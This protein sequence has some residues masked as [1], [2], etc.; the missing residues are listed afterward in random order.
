MKMVLALRHRRLP[1]SLHCETP[2]PHVD[3]SAGEVRLLRETV[4]WQPN[5][6]PRRAGV[7]AFGISGT[8][9]HTII[10]EAPG[11]PA[12]PNES[13]EPAE[14][15]EP[16]GP[17]RPAVLTGGSRA[18]LVSGRTPDGLRAQAARLAEFVSARADQDPDDITD[19]TDV[20]WSLA[21]SRSSFEHRAVVLG[22]D[23]ETLTSGLAALAAGGSAPTVVSGAVPAGRPKVGLLFAGQ[24]AQRAGM[25]RE[26]YAA[27]PAFAA[28]FDQACALLEAELELPIREVVLGDE[29]DERADQTVYAQTG[30]F[31]V[32]VGLVALLAEA[33]IVPDAVA[34]HSV[35]EIAAAHA[36]GVLTLADASRLVA[37]RARLMQDLPAGGAMAAVEAGEA[38][39][40]E[41]LDGLPGVEI[42]AVNGPSA[43]VIS[44]DS[45]AVGQVLETWRER[46]RRV[47]RLRVSHAFHSARM[48]PVLDE[49][50][51]VATGLEHRTPT[52]TWAGAC[53]GTI[54]TAPEPGY[55]PAQAR[56]AV[57]F[58]D[59]VAALAGQGVSVF[60]EIGP[61]ATLSA[62]G[63]AALPA[64][65]A[66]RAETEAAGAAEPVFI[67]LLR[68][69]TSAADAVLTA[70]ARAHV[71]GI[72]VDWTRVLPAGTRV[73]LPTYAFRRQ[74]FW[75]LGP[76]KLRIGPVTGD[77]HA[78]GA[79]EARFWAAVESGDRPALSEALAV[80]DRRLD[81]LLPV[82]AA[83][84]RRERDRSA[85]D[86]WR[87]RISWAPVAD[88]E[89]VTLSGTWLVVT[90]TADAEPAGRCVQALTGHGA[91]AVVV[92]IS[93]ET[94]REALAA[95]LGRAG[96][97][98]ASG[99]VS[100]LALDETP[101]PDRPAVTGGL[102]AT[103]SLIQALGD[104][105]AQ[106]PLWVLTSGAVATDP[107]E[108][109]ARPLQAQVWGLG[110]VAGLEHPER[111]GGLIDLPA[112]LDD[113][114]AGR[115][116][117]V[118]AGNGE[119][120]V[121]IRSAGIRA[122]RLVRAPGPSGT[123]PGDRAARP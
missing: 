65:E 6:R 40:A 114:A 7:S 59:A 29:D 72:G 110:R 43:V 116:C 8:N 73:D 21:T 56:Q 27:S 23:R 76:H 47:R 117:A 22:V 16:A 62:M 102:A 48:D 5:G 97:A 26:L 36:A 38:E 41:T 3:W 46:G 111:W 53:D 119:D 33:G 108:P 42:A 75:P 123:R 93:A 91:E 100:L 9:A 77:D 11:L 55:W 121:A 92:R 107:G 83:W 13:I 84:R 122:R 44:G 105:Q 64:A 63:P 109:P 54:L 95:E 34:G 71:H 98:R 94:T 4:E 52:V 81:D 78:G 25:G 99:V 2:S 67:P 1:R 74:R 66:A 90:G 14:P 45:E 85:T 89:P 15:I 31:A 28:A 19:I 18:W 69:R 30:L 10:E 86:T 80:D 68:P 57:R 32:E 35:G 82:L 112:G 115:L 58:A 12:E 104:A 96:V 37:A 118:L 87:Y 17:A 106:A 103:L 50:R 39:M 120:Q 60:M 49:L 61:D 101:L 24:G 70:L 51:R 20:A 113:R 88:P 79:A